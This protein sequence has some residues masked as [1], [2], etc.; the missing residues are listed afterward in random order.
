MPTSAVQPSV[1]L[2]PTVPSVSAEAT[3]CQ[4]HVTQ[5]QSVKVRTLVQSCRYS[6]S[7]NKPHSDSGSVCL[8]FSSGL[9]CT[10]KH[11]QSVTVAMGFS[12]ITPHLLMKIFPAHDANPYV[13]RLN[14]LSGLPDMV[15]YVNCLF[16]FWVVLYYSMQVPDLFL[17][18]DSWL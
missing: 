11:S 13:L 10:L 15:H 4:E 2:Q 14:A 16:T 17:H 3:T 5:E 1:N 7:F 9:K 18:F 12:N 6:M 8:G